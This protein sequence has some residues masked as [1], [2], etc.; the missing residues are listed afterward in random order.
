MRARRVKRLAVLLA[1]LTAAALWTRSAH[2]GEEP[3]LY[4][5][6]RSHVDM[7]TPEGSN[8]DRDAEGETESAEADT[9]AAVP[10]ELYADIIAGISG[11]EP[12]CHQM[13]CCWQRG[14]ST[15]LD[16]CHYVKGLAETV[17]EISSSHGA[18]DGD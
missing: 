7:S 11:N 12:G 14:A 8:Q 2:A 1:S 3:G 4:G 16:H 9:A 5:D 15:G 10:L 17:I 18:E 13:Q 6:P